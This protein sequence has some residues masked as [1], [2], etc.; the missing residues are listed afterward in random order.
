MSS[1]R[2]LQ[3]NGLCYNLPR[4]I[5]DVLSVLYRKVSLE[6]H[7]C[8]GRVAWLRGGDT[9]RQGTLQVPLDDFMWAM[10]CPDSSL[11]TPKSFDHITPL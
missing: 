9:V 1:Q 4:T 5:N 11:I 3:L 7:F 8:S 6:L 2:Y 10:P